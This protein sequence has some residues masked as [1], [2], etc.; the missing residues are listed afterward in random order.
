MN[1]VKN[2]EILDI[3]ADSLERAN[4]YRNVLLERLAEL[5]EK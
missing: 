4:K 3:P 1:Q 2:Y 5:D